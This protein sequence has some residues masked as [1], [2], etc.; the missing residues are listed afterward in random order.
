MVRGEALLARIANCWL[1]KGLSYITSFMRKRRKLIQTGAC[2]VLVILTILVFRPNAEREPFSGGRSLSSLLLDSNHR[3]TPEARKSINESINHIGVSA[4]PFL[5]KW[6]QYER[7][8]WRDKVAAKLGKIP[9]KPILIL[10]RDVKHPEREKLA[11]ATVQGFFVLG[12]KATPVMDKLLQLQAN[13]KSDRTASRAS[14]ALTNIGR[15]AMPELTAAIKD[16]NHS[17]RLDALRSIIFLVTYD[18]IDRAT[19]PVQVLTNALADSDIQVRYYAAQALHVFA[20]AIYT[21]NPSPV[22]PQASTH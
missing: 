12:A 21:N 8:P 2:V 14:S 11:D 15:R 10:A 20:P 13:W 1:K 7:P 9:F 3:L 17:G 4:F 16:P 22:T 6:I 18:K 19:F 5:F